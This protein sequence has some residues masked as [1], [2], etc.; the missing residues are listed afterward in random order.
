MY[1]VGEEMKEDDLR[2]E[3][4]KGEDRFLSTVSNALEPVVVLYANNISPEFQC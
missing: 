3:E 2:C 1:S 4:R